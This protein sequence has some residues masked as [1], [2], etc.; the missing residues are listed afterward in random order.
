MIVVSNPTNFLPS[1]ASNCWLSS[2]IGPFKCCGT[3]MPDC[4]LFHQVARGDRSGVDGIPML[5]KIPRMFDPWGGLQHYR[6]WRHPSTWIADSILTQVCTCY[7]FS[8]QM[9]HLTYFS[10]CLFFFFLFF[11]LK[12]KNHFLMS[13]PL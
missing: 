9:F 1:I 5:L 2:T 10:T 7:C 6:I 4:I 13:I 11:S 3:N 12:K 8:C